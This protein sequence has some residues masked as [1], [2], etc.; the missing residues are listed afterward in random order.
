MP[1]RAAS[2]LRVSIKTVESHMVLLKDT[3]VPS[4][5]VYSQCQHKHETFG[6]ITC[7]RLRCVEK[8]QMSLL[9]LRDGGGPLRQD[10]VPQQLPTQHRRDH[11]DPWLAGQN[12][13]P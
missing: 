3:Q 4:L 12:T 5:G 9:C 1:S 6:H 8:L 7:V 11:A 13:T 2:G 10:R